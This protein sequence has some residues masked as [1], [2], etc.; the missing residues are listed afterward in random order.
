MFFKLSFMFFG[1]FSSVHG[2]R[3]KTGL[4]SVESSKNKQRVINI[5]WQFDFSLDRIPEVWRRGSAI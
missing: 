4:C 1:S 3:S 5:K 2:I